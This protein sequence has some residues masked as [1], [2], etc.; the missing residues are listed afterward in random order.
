MVA[1]LFE[2][3]YRSINS[4]CFI[5]P[6]VHRGDHWWCGLQPEQ[7]QPVDGQHSRT[8]SHSVSQTGQTLQIHWYVSSCI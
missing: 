2:S 8:L 5:G 3:K 7:S 1:Y 4:V 6:S